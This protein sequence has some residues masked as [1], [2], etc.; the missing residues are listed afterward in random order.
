MAP[1]AFS[2]AAKRLLKAG[3]VFG[4]TT[5]VGGI[6]AVTG[7]SEDAISASAAEL[8]RAEILEL[9]PRGRFHGQVELVFRHALLRDAA[10]ELLFDAE[11]VEAHRRAALWLAESGERDPLT[12]ARH[13]AR[14]GLATQAIPHRTR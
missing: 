5:W 10:Y 7:E 2:A 13:F 12:L 3:S 4:E 9:L 11:R 8:V 1:N 14:G 6:A